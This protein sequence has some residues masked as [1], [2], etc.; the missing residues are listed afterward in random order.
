MRIIRKTVGPVGTNAYF[1]INGESGECLLVDPG[2]QPEVLQGVLRQEGLKLKAILL[3][4]GHFDHI[5]AVPALKE[6][7]GVPVLAGEKERPLLADP[8]L[9]S[10]GLWP[11]RVSLVPDK[12]LRDGDRLE[13]AGL[14]LQVLETPGHTPGGICYFL[15][16]EQAVFTGDTLF[17]GS[18]G[19]TD[20][21]GG[22]DAEILRSVRR[23][24]RELPA[25][26]QVYPGHGGASRIEFERL[27]N[28]LAE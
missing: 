23:L 28:P 25:E 4:H 11:N 19:R 27:I 21:Y 5:Q 24:L 22:S 20:L 10:G 14:K 9:S 13:L 15:P 16:D 17:Q 18:Y 1:L 2:D 8:G 6:A 12:G 3:T 26:T 7:F